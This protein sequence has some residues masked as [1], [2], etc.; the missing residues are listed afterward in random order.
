MTNLNSKLITLMLA[1][2]LAAC[3]GGGGGGSGSA[4]VT[5]P[6]VGGGGSGG[7]GDPADPDPDAFLA[8]LP[9]WDAFAP[10]T[11]DE[12]NEGV[13]I[14]DASEAPV[15]E[16]VTDPNNNLKVCT[17]EKVDFYNTPEEY[18]M[19]SPP[20]NVLYPGA[21][22][23][24]ESLRDGATAGDILP[25]NVAQRTPV[26]VTI[27]AC[28]IVNNFREVQPTLAA[29]NSAVSDIISEAEQLNADCINAQGNLRV[30]TYR[31]ERQR[32]LRAGISGRYFGF[33]GSASGSFSQQ[34]SENSVAA[35]FRETLYTVDISAPQ[36]PAGWFS[37]AFTPEL[38]QQ[39]IDL[40]TMGADNVPAYV[41]R[42]TY[43]RI[44][45]STMTS[46]YSE[47]EMRAA[48]EFKYNNP[49]AQVTGDAAARS[50]TI[51][52]QSRLTLSY[53]GGSAEAT[54]AML[55]SNDWTQYF[56]VPVT[57]S[58]AV[59]ISFELRSVSD[60][61][62][63]VV[64]EFTSYDRTTCTDKLGGDETFTFSNE[65]I[66]DP[67]FSAAGQQ[68]AVGDLDGRNGDD[69]VWAA[70]GA[71]ARGEIAV[72]FSNGDGT[73]EALSLGEHTAVN[74]ELGNFTLQLMDVDADGCKDIVLNLLGNGRN[75]AYV[76][77]VKGDA[78][79]EFVYSAPQEL[80]SAGAWQEHTPFAGQMDA[81]LG[82]DLVFNNVPNSVT[83]NSTYTALAVDT[84]VPG[85][86]LETGVLFEPLQRFD[87]DLNFSNYDFTYV[88]DFNGDGFDDIAWQVLS[89]VDNRRWFAMGSANGLTGVRFQDLRGN[90]ARFTSV[91]GDATGD[92]LADIVEPRALGTWEAFTVFIGEGSGS[93]ANADADVL[94]PHTPKAR[95]RTPEDIAIRDLFGPAQD[96]GS[97]GGLAAWSSDIY[98][99][100]VDGNGTDDMLINDKGYG[101]NLTNSIGVGLAIA[102]GSEF[103][104]TR[105]AQ[106]LAPAEDWS[107][108][109][110]L[111]GDINDDGRT[112]VLWISNA[113]VNSVFAAVARG[114]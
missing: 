20:T 113:A 31:N 51:R 56:G 73:F 39:Q 83:R 22:V 3:G 48:F 69:I 63:A 101:N 37:D 70:S 29:I 72:A 87:I 64:Q 5:P 50:Q 58:D 55:Q 30:E 67:E 54:T 109:R 52:E 34:A 47:Q 114:E 86:D 46:T 111:S 65:L 40:G 62:P 14:V 53:L 11:R 99:V 96:S 15:I 80:A 12:A 18:V 23:V 4:P 16:D 60:N 8:A 100:D 2:T 19:F 77:F 94:D 92:G 66:F 6:P 25:I 102:G 45:T 81:Q 36:T 105:V 97:P 42:V 24:G 61:V 107:Q 89:D 110:L 1:I 93:A 79:R 76:V 44:L 74:G 27:A 7:G 95:N 75:T 68:V 43:G 10:K 26:T 78:N 82:A 106:T 103:T 98:L 108:Y 49:V 33:S 112:D 91:L 59:P 21:L 28:N 41:A 35:V 57:A 88:A 71:S 85:F 84:T 104:F 13:E 32:A 9:A 90:W 17:T 38:L